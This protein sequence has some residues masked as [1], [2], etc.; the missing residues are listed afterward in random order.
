MLPPVCHGCRPGHRECLAGSR[1][2]VTHHRA[3]RNTAKLLHRRQ[4]T[5][6]SGLVLPL[7]CHGGG[8]GHRECLASSR[9]SVAHHR[10]YRNTA[11]LLHRRQQTLPPVGCCPWCVMAVLVTLSMIC[12][13]WPASMG[14]HPPWQPVNVPS[15]CYCYCYMT[16]NI[17]LLVFF[18][19]SLKRREVKQWWWLPLYPSSAAV[20]TSVAAVLNTAS[21]LALCMIPSSLNDQSIFWLFTMPFFGSRLQ[22]MFTV[23]KQHQLSY[24]SCCFSVARSFCIDLPSLN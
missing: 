23:C 6:P 21:W 22:W 15:H 12:D 10:A 1:L 11:T 20:M 19:N 3:Y 13:R 8:P 16:N 5:L 24:L 17:L 18:S 14:L 4:Q 9:L 7:V 2:S